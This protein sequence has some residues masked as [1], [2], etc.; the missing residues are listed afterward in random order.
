MQPQ[1]PVDSDGPAETR[2]QNSG[3]RYWAPLVT[4]SV[5]MFIG[6]IDSSMMN[7]AVPAIVSDLQTDVTSVQAAITFYGLVMASLMLPAGRVATM[8]GIKRIY[9]LSLV[10]YGIGTL[11]AAISWNMGVLFLGWS[12]IEGIAAAV[13][14]PIGFTLIA[15]NYEGKHRAMGLGLLA[16]VSAAA[17]ALGPIFGGILTTFFTWR[18]GF[19]GEFILTLVALALVPFVADYRDSDVTLDWV[20]A[21]L[22]IVGIGAVVLGFI[23]GGKFGWV[24][25]TRPFEVGG[26]QVNPV[27]LSPTVWLLL[28]GLVFIVAFVHWQIRRERRGKT[29]LLPIRVVQNAGFVS[30]AATWVFRSV[31]LAGFLFVV[32]L[33]LQSAAGFSAFES[34]LALLPFSIAGFVFALGTTGWRKRVQPKYLIQ[35]GAIAM[36]VGVLL[37]Y[38]QTST[39]MTITSM[40]LPMAVIGV[41]LGLIMGQI[42]ELTLSSVDETDVSEASSTLNATGMLGYAVGTAIFGSALLSSFYGSVVDGVLRTEGITATAQERQ[43]IVIRL[44]D[45]REIVT[46]AEREA[47][48]AALPPETQ[49]VLFELVQDAMVASMELTLL[50]VAGVTAVMLAVATFLPSHREEEVSVTDVVDPS[51]PV[52]RADD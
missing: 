9:A 3:F 17:A 8:Y 46:E 23:L 43:E 11:L 38:R 12:V 32:P 4:V 51:D 13:L 33:F 45:A 44:Q 39:T 24:R 1:T 41:G 28:L 36:V 2:E 26:T 30:G 48:Y 27:G 35:I 47:A 50:L 20:G 42:V 18:Y 34:G 49:Q 25:A 31:A 22:S 10:F 37:F 7:V 15:I 21:L 16:G 14:L 29:P 6:T 40:I 52:I 5:A 19:A